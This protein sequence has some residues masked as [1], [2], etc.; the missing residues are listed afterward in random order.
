MNFLYLCGINFVFLLYFLSGILTIDRS[1]Q[2]VLDYYMRFRTTLL[3]KTPYK[4]S[5]IMTRNQAKR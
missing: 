3:D 4:K 5:L 2:N 1:K